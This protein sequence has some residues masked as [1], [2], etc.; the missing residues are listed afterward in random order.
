MTHRCTLS[1]AYVRC[2]DLPFRQRGRRCFCFIFLVIPGPVEPHL[3]APYIRRTLCTFRKYGPDVGAVRGQPLLV[4]QVT[5]TSDGSLAVTTLRHRIFL[6]GVYGDTPANRKLSLHLGHMALLAC[7]YCFGK[8]Q[9]CGGATCF[10]GYCS[11]VPTGCPPALRQLGPDFAA[12]PATAKC[13]DAGV[14]LSSDMQRARAAELPVQ[15]ARAPNATARATVI[16]EFGIH[17]ESLFAELLGHYV[18][19]NNL[20]VVPV[21]HAAL[22][23][24]EKQFLAVVLRDPGSLPVSALPPWIVR[25]DCRKIMAR[26]AGHVILTNDFNRPYR[27]V[28][29]QRGNWVMEDYLHFLEY[30]RY[31]FHDEAGRSLFPCPDVKAAWES[32]RAGIL[33][34]FRYEEGG[35]S[36][37]AR[38]A[39]FYNL[40]DFAQRW[41]RL[42]GL[43][44][45]TYNLHLLLCRLHDQES[46]RGH[47]SHETDFWVE[48]MIQ[49]MKSDVKFRTTGCAELLFLNGL[50]L[51]DAVATMRAAPHIGDWDGGLLDGGSRAP[52]CDAREAA[53]AAAARDEGGRYEGVIFMALGHGTPL[54]QQNGQHAI[55]LWSG[56]GSG[57]LGDC[58]NAVIGPDWAALLGSDGLDGAVSVTSFSRACKEGGDE[59]QSEQH[60]R[61]RTRE[62]FWAV[63][64]F[65]EADGVGGEREVPYVARILR[66]LKF[67]SL[68][69]EALRAAEVALYRCSKPA[70][71]LYQVD[72]YGEGGADNYWPNYMVPLPCFAHKVF[73]CSTGASSHFFVRYTVFSRTIGG[74]MIEG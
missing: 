22:I 2:A 60:S 27:C 33:H 59:L 41:E 58:G 3:I 19:P 1:C 51:D 47:V 53:G 46:A 38:S 65:L 20:W 15:L 63:C 6:S 39:A 61:A 5:R 21:A 42:V 72:R 24:V 44:G 49:Y 52:W 7:P 71:G 67:E 50:L 74:E 37:D 31:I 45:C 54:S 40:Y 73:H 35:F 26:R 66:F 8:A 57:Y 25:A 55:S 64:M 34:Y 30:S 48:R 16:K 9:K 36:D 29:K 68:Q 10:G 70:P 13:G 62:S 32:L 18:D 12:V 23:G 4:Q 11:A 43:R 17:G 14:K 56:G 69:L 28:I